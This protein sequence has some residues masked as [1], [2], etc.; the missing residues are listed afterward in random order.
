MKNDYSKQ[1]GRSSANANVN[2]EET[3][4]E[5]GGNAEGRV[6]RNVEKPKGN[7]KVK[8]TVIGAVAGAA[9]GIGGTILGNE[10]YAQDNEVEENQVNQEN[11]EN[12]E[13][14]ENQDP[15]QPDEQDMSFDEAFAQARAQ[16]GPGQVFEWHGNSYTTDYQEEV[17]AQENEEVVADVEE[18]AEVSQEEDVQED[19][20]VVPEEE[21]DVEENVEV[22]SEVEE[23][24]EVSQ[25]EDVQGDVELVPEEEAGVEENVEVTSEVEENAEVTAEEPVAEPEIEIVPEPDEPDI[26]ASEP[27]EP[28]ADYT[29]DAVL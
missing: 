6:K 11:Q 12:Q 21:A 16:M 22:T 3:V 7:S 20:E 25:Q 19:V 15:V 9:V 17:N 1:T 29:N 2:D 13:G 28:D 5:E 14:Q 27:Y 26:A 24:V 10:L 18:N 23:N 8:K 4:F